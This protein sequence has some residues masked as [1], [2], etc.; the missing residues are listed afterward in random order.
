MGL[1]QKSC[2]TTPPPRLIKYIKTYIHA[3]LIGFF[4]HK[5][6]LNM[7]PIFYKN[8][9]KHGS[10]FSDWDN[11]FGFSHGE[12]QKLWRMRLYFETNP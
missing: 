5:K 7:G 4:F 6:S 9:P 12:N 10:T 2:G 11:I 8:N 1:F 3:A